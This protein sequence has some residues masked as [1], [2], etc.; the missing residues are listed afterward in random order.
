M[1]KKWTVLGVF[2]VSLV[3]V[4]LWIVSLQDVRIRRIAAQVTRD[5]LGVYREALR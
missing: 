2:L 3:I 5:M 1:D 4:H